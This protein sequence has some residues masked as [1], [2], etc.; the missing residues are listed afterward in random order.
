[1]T[2]EYIF[3]E[4]AQNRSVFKHLLSGI[5]EKLHRWRPAPDKWCLLEIVGHL[6]D[7]ERFDFRARVRHCLLTPEKPLKPIN[8]AGWVQEHRYMEQDFEHQVAVFLRERQRSVRWLAKLSSPDWSS[9]IDH[10]NLGRMTAGKFL[11]NWLEHDYL[12]IRQILTL[13]HRYLKITSG[14]DLSY[15]GNWGD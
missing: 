10:P 1:M 7:E 9:G 8:P 2:P 4:L 13:K 11:V 3:G 15:A 6:C 12:H 14:E 5:D